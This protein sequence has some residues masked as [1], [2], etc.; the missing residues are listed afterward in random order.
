MPKSWEQVAK[1]GPEL[2]DMTFFAYELAKNPTN[3][4]YLEAE[5]YL[6]DK[7]YN[8]GKYNKQLP[9]CLAMVGKNQAKVILKLFD[10]I[11]RQNYTNYRIALMDD[12]SDDGTVQKLIEYLGNHTKLKDRSNIVVQPYERNALY[13]RHFANTRIC[14]KG[15]IIIDLD[16]DDYL[17]GSQVFQLVNSLYQ[18]GYDYKGKK[19]EVW[20]LFMNF[21][22]SGW[23]STGDIPTSLFFGQVPA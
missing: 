7:K 12:N 10:S 19:E 21:I 14:Q 6:Y 5:Y 1:Q 16:T 20:S 4:D 18:S 9:L 23:S 22:V 2:V 11:L 13:N 17:I 3:K 8:I 15:D